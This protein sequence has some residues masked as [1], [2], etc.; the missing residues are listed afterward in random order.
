MLDLLDFIDPG[1]HAAIFSGQGVYADAAFAH[2][3]SYGVGLGTLPAIR[4][5]AGKLKFAATIHLKHMVRLCGQGSGL[6]S[7]PITT[8]EFDPGL[9]GIVVHR[10]DTNGGGLETPP[11]TGADGAIIEGVFLTGSGAS[12]HGVWMRARA[13]VRDCMIAGFGQNGVNIVA[14]TTTSDPFGHGNANNWRLDTMRIVNCG[15]HGVFV[16]GGDVNAGKATAVDVTSNHGWGI[17]DSGFLGNEWDA[18]HAAN[19]TFGAYKT[20][21]PNARHAFISCYS[22][23]GQPASSFVWPT[24]VIGGLHGAGISGTGMV[25]GDGSI[26]PFS[27]SQNA[28]RALQLSLQ[29]LPN[30]FLEFS[31]AGDHPHGWSIYWQNGT[32]TVQFRHALLDMRIA[33]MLTTDISTLIDDSGARIPAGNIVFPNSIY[34][35][36][37]LG[38]YK[39]A[40]F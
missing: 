35:P 17:F 10:A 20:D 18:C 6:A 22:E 12:G 15:G 9:H 13:F 28:G 16:D 30:A 37:A 25:I 8:L 1:Q 38:N 40:V 31:A 14:D 7:D 33:F 3:V 2:A 23:S 27:M 26:S 32:N 34:V 36:S 21:N 24:V 29:A 5:P 19:N 39:K 11:T 4:L